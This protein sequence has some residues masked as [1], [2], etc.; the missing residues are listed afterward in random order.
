MSPE[1][2]VHQCPLKDLIMLMH[3]ADP[4]NKS[5]L[6]DY[7][8]INGG[9]VAF[10]GNSKGGKITGKGIEN[11][12]DLRVKVIRCD[13]GTEFK[14]RAMNQFCEMKGIKRK[15]S[16]A[17]TPQQNGVAERKNK[18][19][20]EAA[21]TMPANSKLPTTFWAE[22]VNTACKK[23]A[24]SFMRPFEYLVTILNTIDH[25][26]KFDGKANEGLF[27]G[28]Y[29]NSKAFRVFNS[30]TRIVEENLHVKFSKNTPYIAESGPNWLFDID[31]LTKSMNYKPVVAGNQSNGSAGTKACDNVGGKKKDVEELGNEDSKV[32]KNNVFDENI[33]YGCADD[34]NLHDL[35]EIVKFSDVE[36]DD[37][38][39]D[40][41]ILDT[42]FQMDVKNAFLY[43][44]IKEEVYVCQPSGF[45]DLDFSDKVYK[46]EKELYEL[47]Q[48]PRA[49]KE[50][51]IEFE[52]M[53]HKK[54]QMSS[55]RELIFFL[56]QQVKQKKYG[57]FISQDNQDKY[58]NEILNKFGFSDV[59]TAST[60]ME[61]H[62]TLLKDKKG[63]DVDEHLYRSMIGSLMYLTSSR[64]DIIFT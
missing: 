50:M 9:F 36:N 46:V 58:V 26:G 30:R 52:K 15:F 19:L 10:G 37:S 8:E 27:I 33:V 44:K 40:M 13:N 25:L 28:Y 21:R 5:Y 35:E 64:P 56:G 60:P 42:Y 45:E 49:W 47:Y 51:C 62:K 55:I 53:M 54:F 61:T 22:A 7:K 23:P 14:N 16:V 12:I 63:E 43:G 29:T 2:M 34:P 4:R 32:L 3:K 41:K 6:K 48:A 39:A 31:A 20:I 57:F 24:L 1:T 38:G 17:G 11:L 59:K 18:T